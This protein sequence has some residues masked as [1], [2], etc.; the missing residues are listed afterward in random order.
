L[1]EG[2]AAPSAASPAP[3]PEGGPVTDVASSSPSRS[4]NGAGVKR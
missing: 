3:K 1:P 2:G 4:T